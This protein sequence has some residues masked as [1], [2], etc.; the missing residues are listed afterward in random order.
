[1]EYI[2]TGYSDPGT[3]LSLAQ[4]SHYQQQGREGKFDMATTYPDAEP[5]SGSSSFRE[6]LRENGRA[7]VPAAQWVSGGMFLDLRL[8]L[9]FMSGLHYL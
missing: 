2:S 7:T 4:P 8:A 1:M 6:E 9:F 5:E 3:P